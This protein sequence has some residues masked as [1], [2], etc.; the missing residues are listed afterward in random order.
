MEPPT[1]K[2]FIAIAGSLRKESLHKRLLHEVAAIAT[3]INITITIIHLN[4][5]PLPLF[6]E[7][8][9]QTENP[10]ITNLRQLISI[11]DGLIIA[12]PE[13]NGS[14]S[15]VLKNTIDW[16]S[17]DRTFF[18]NKKIAIMS[19]SPSPH[20][21]TTGLSHLRDI[22]THTKA[23]VIKTQISIPNIKYNQTTIITEP[24]RQQIYQLLELEL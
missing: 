6:N 13:Y 1:K 23:N 15:A 2:H 16:L 14:I 19:C 5:Y 17:R 8:I 12:S 4:D 11:S 18:K 7:D 20:G 9:E 22:L 3:Q 21:G 24:I 10:T